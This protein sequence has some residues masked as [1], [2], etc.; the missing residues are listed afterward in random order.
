MRRTAGMD[1]R[2]SSHVLLMSPA[3]AS[4]KLHN[5]HCCGTCSQ[6]QAMQQ[7]DILLAAGAHP[8]NAQHM[9]LIPGRLTCAR[10]AVLLHPGF[11]GIQLLASLC[12]LQLQLM[13]QRYMR[14]ELIQSQKLT[15]LG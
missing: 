4:R 7:V 5:H 12:E 3:Y 10:K 9:R 11:A 15:C 1:Q 8:S 14:L 6:K 2:M 13:M